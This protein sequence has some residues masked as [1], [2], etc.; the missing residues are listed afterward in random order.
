VT[1]VVLY[2]HSWERTLRGNTIVRISKK[3]QYAVGDSI[4]VGNPAAGFSINPCID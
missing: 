4:A 1:L 3:T 2:L